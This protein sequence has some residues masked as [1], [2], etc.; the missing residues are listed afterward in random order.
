MLDIGFILASESR[1]VS[2]TL[3]YRSE[4]ESHFGKTED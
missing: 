3:H 4:Y 2:D 1:S